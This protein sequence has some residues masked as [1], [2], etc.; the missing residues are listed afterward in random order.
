VADV[1]DAQSLQQVRDHKRAAKAA[2]RAT[3]GS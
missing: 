2:A 3:M 1:V